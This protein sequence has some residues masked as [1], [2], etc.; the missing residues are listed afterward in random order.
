MPDYWV[1]WISNRTVRGE[2]SLRWSLPFA[3]PR[4]ARQWAKSH[5]DEGKATLATVWAFEDDGP[6][7]LVATYPRSAGMVIGHYLDMAAH[8]GKGPPP[9]SKGRSEP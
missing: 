5:V 1:Y 4:E 2:S 8:A 6:G 7:K 3:E 9:S